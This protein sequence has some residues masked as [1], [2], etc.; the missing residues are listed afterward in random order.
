M[1]TYWVDGKEPDG[2]TTSST[3]R[4]MSL[5]PW[6]TPPRSSSTLQP[7]LSPAPL[8]RTLRRWVYCV[9]CWLVVTK[10]HKSTGVEVLHIQL[11]AGTNVA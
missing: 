4:S 3:S 10:R 6:I 2:E 8:S 9:L 1:K 11:L 7:R 5:S